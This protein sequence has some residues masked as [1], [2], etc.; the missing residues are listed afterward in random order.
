MSEYQVEFEPRQLVR[1]AAPGE[2]LP[3]YTLDELLRGVCHVVR[4]SDADIKARLARNRGIANASIARQKRKETD[5]TERFAA[6]KKMLEN[7]KT[8]LEISIV[9]ELTV[10]T[11]QRYVSRH[12]V[13]R[14]LSMENPRYER[15]DKHSQKRFL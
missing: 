13:L 3:V 8:A 9:L 5:M 10:K 12:A 4:L 11:V 7:H 1:K 15:K 14:D 2:L 6:V